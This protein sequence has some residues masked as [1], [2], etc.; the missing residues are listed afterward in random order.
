MSNVSNRAIQIKRC[1]DALDGSGTTIRRKVKSDSIFA[2]KFA[3]S[4]LTF[5]RESENHVEQSNQQ[6]DL[7]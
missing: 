4:W 2:F 6:L 7:F 5:V 1:G 3:N